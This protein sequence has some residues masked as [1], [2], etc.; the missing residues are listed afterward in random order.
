MKPK[1]RSK[2]HKSGGERPV[3]D[4]QLVTACLGRLEVEAAPGIAARLALYCEELLHWSRRVDLT[5]ARTAEELV[6]GPFFDALTLLPVVSGT[7]KL[8]DVGSGG[9]L[10]G[11]PLALL[12]PELEVTLLEPRTRRAAFLRHVCGLLKVPCPVHE[13][14]LEE[15]A[16][17]SFD[18]AVA[19]AV[20]PPREWLERARLVVRPGGAIYVLSAAPLSLADLQSGAALEAE[21]GFAGRKTERFAARVRLATGE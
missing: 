16:P 20:W 8:L 3:V 4:P 14:R 15:V 7:G 9:G 5:G 10:P 17:R 1:A 11:I 13:G 18:Q 21:R 12:R 6:D 2:S 19:Q